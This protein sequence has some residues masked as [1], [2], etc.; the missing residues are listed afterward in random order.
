MLHAQRVAPRGKFLLGW[1]LGHWRDDRRGL[2]E[3]HPAWNSRRLS[4]EAPPKSMSPGT[5]ST[6]MHSPPLDT[7]AA[8]AAL[9]ALVLP[10]DVPVGDIIVGV[11]EANCTLLTDGAG[12]AVRQ[13]I[14][15][16]PAAGQVGAAAV[17]DAL[18][19]HGYITP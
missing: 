1:L 10:E 9:E 2:S 17:N 13:D 5:S 3:L 15:V 16:A 6:S 11:R 12:L 14:G 18:I 8:Y 7:G 4:K 19:V